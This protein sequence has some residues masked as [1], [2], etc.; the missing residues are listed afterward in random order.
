VT[1]AVDPIENANDFV[2]RLG[3]LVEG[4]QLPGVLGLDDRL[5]RAQEP[6]SFVGVLV[7]NGGPRLLLTIATIPPQPQ[8]VQPQAD[9]L[10]GDDEEPG[11]KVH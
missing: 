3:D 9:E 4:G 1:D 10:E 8:A 6:G 11:S 2:D 5:G 7:L